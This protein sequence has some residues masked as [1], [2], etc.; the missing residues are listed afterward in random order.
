MGN[1]KFPQP[2]P[3]SRLPARR[4]HPLQPVN[5]GTLTGSQ[6]PTHAAHA[7]AHTARIEGLATC[8]VLPTANGKHHGPLYCFPWTVLVARGCR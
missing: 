1:L 7:A 5:T 8:K 2:F 3:H 4:T 6:L